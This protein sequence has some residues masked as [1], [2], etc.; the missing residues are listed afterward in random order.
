MLEIYIFLFYAIMI[1][2][3]I[4]KEIFIRVKIKFVVAIGSKMCFCSLSIK[5]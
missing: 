2:T 1:L 4:A 5:I 3:L